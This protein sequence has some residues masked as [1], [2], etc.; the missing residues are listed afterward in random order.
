MTTVVNNPGSAE[1]GSSMGM[2]LGVILALILVGLFFVYGLPALQGAPSTQSGSTN[3][4]VTLPNTGGT[5]A[6][7][8]SP[9]PLY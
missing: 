3:I 5:P 2:V 9:A 6:P 7:A 8:P 1:G 4:N